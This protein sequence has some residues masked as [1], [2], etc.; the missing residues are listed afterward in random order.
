M[1]ELR[2]DFAEVRDFETI[3]ERLLEFF[4][5]YPVKVRYVEVA[6]RQAGA[7]AD[8]DRNREVAT[9]DEANDFAGVIAESIVE[10]VKGRD[11]QAYSS[12][13]VVIPA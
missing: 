6:F 4:R 9:T 12:A 5:D 10:Y 3:K 8:T 13:T 11:G 1:K 2:F 7:S